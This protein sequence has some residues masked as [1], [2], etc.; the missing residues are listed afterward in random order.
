MPRILE[1]AGSYKCQGYCKRPEAA[2]AKDAVGD[3]KLQ[4]PWM[5]EASGSC[6]GNDAGGGRK[7][8]VPTVAQP[9]R[10]WLEDIRRQSLNFT[11]AQFLVGLC[12]S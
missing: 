12:E 6:S 9:D 2:S 1:I 10:R 7:L 5:M 3:R 11:I 8:Q 4:V